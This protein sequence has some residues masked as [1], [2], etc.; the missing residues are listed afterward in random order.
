MKNNS[1]AN[2]SASSL[3]TYIIGFAGSLVLT[4]IPFALVM[5]T[6]LVPATVLII[7]TLFAVAQIL[8]HLVCFLHLK[9]SSQNAWNGLALIYTVILLVMLVGASIWIMYQLKHNMT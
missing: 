8:L 1:L 3:R 2:F 4:I 7:I 9:P 6:T 5:F